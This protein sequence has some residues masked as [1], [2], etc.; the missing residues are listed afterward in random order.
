MATKDK[1]FEPSIKDLVTPGDVVQV[2]PYTAEGG[3]VEGFGGC[4]MVIT[5]VRQGSPYAVGYVNQPGRPD[6]PLFT[7]IRWT[8]LEY[9]G[10]ARW[11][12][13]EHI[14]GRLKEAMKQAQETAVAA[15][16]K[17]RKTASAK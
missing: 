17:V 9:V 3:G 11:M 16:K 14:Q 7:R 1:Y 10:R 2:R 13:E 5:E 4:F 15:P 12:H 8:D 6:V